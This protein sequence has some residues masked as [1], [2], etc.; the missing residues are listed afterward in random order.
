MLNIIISSIIALALSVG[1]WF[2]LQ[3][4]RNTTFGAFGDPFL[5]VQVGTSPQN[6]YYLQT[7]GTNSSWQPVVSGGGSGG[8]T[9]S[10]TTSQTSGVLFNY[11]N[12]TTDVVLI[13]SNSSTTAEV[14]FD[15]NNQRFQIGN[16]ASA[17]TTLLG[18][19]RLPSLTQGFLYTGS[20]GLVSTMSSSTIRTSWLTNDSNFITL[21]S[22][23]G[24]YPISYNSGTG[25]ISYSGLATSSSWTA[26][27]LSY[28]INGNTLR[29]VSTTTLTASSPLSLSQPISVIGSS[30]SS[31]SLDTSGTW[32]GTAGSVANSLTAGSG[33]TSAGTYNGS[34]ARTFSL[35]T[36]NANTWTTLQTFSNSSTSL[37]SFSYASSTGY[38]G[39]GLT[40]CSGGNFLT[41]TNGFFGCGADQTGSGGSSAYEIATTSTI[42]VPQVAY[43]TQTGGRTTLGSVATGTI[44]VPTGLTVTANRYTLGGATAIGLDT[45]YVIPLQTTLD[46]KLTAL[47]SGYATT[48]QSAIAFSTST[49][50]FNGLT[51]GQTIVPSAGAMTF[52]PTISGTLNNAG[53]TNST[54]SGISLGSNLADLTAGNSSLTFSGT[55]NGG[56][57]RNIV[58]NMGNANSWTAL[59]TFTNSSTTLAS[60]SYASSTLWYGG[61][62]TT[63]SGSNFLQWSG[64]VF[65]CGTPAGSGTPGGSDTQVQFNDGGSF[66]G[67]VAWIWNKTREVMGIGTTTPFANH[68]V[69]IASSTGQQLALLTG[70]N[71][72]GWGFRNAGGTLYVGTTSPLTGA[73][74]TT[75]VLTLTSNATASLTV[76]T[77]TAG[78]AYFSSTGE[79]YSQTC[80]GGGSVTSVIA[81]VGFH[82][83]GL[84]ITTSGT[85]NAGIS[86][87]S[88]PT[89]GQL[90]YWTGIGD[91]SNGATVGSVATSTLATGN[92]LT[93]TG[94]LG[95]QVGGTNSTISI[96][97]TGLVTNALVTWNGSN[98]VATGTP[99]LTIGTLTSTSTATSTFAGR[100]HIGTTTPTSG[101]SA[102]FSVKSLMNIVAQFFTS[103]GTKIMEIADSGLVTLLG[104]WNFGEATSL[105]IPNSTSPT[106][107]AGGILALDTTSNN[108]IM[109]TSTNG[110]FVVGSATTTLY[111][112][113]IASTS[114]DAISGGIIYLPDH[115]N[116]QVVTAIS[117]FVD[118]GT[119][120]VINLSNDA[121]SS[122]T[123]TATCTTSRGQYAITSNNSYASYGGIRLELGTKTGSWD[124][125]T[126]R[127][128][129]YRTSN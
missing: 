22:L 118:G 119:S 55:Y 127:V 44:S 46:S 52:T 21:S 114:P 107:G 43:F 92:G 82:N 115:P 124:Y 18:N 13:G 70:G 106:L 84:N 78:C 60:F 8:G 111:S 61:G 110:H 113:S 81:G 4:M 76:S 57:A 121:G 63:C 3:E 15:P 85:L 49:A 103:A 123:N 33:L 38:F 1:G 99:N 48:T 77:T 41:W 72:N 66:G 24:S 101:G 12:N 53:L 88:N 122:D 109:A 56:T 102:T 50:T 105:E 47:G 5:S 20:G 26:G 73:T 116:A 27:Q 2:G 54:I 34:V 129:G 62:L 40:S 37:A 91:A 14:Y 39:A 96:N 100:L 36:A 95:S 87:S 98:L 59:Q 10:T 17:S 117:C 51:F 69:S 80:A 89:L 128:M 94:T 58:L 108:L 30:A 9:W 29:G 35:N 16:S 19:F 42:A 7:D 28:V 64:G 11:P 71:D 86:T 90:T 74:S 6:G 126:I 104:T 93:V 25:A 112:F 120:Q 32:T 83:R 67:A 31:L 97:S 45:G 23:S 125:L 68:K 65:G 75:P 79:I